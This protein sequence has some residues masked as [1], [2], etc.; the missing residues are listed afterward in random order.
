M[1]ETLSAVIGTEGAEW[2]RFLFSQKMKKKNASFVIANERLPE[3]PNKI[4]K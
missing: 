2:E 1:N 4:S 3:R